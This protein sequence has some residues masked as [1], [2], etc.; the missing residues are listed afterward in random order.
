[1]MCTEQEQAIQKNI[2]LGSEELKKVDAFQYLGSV[3][4]AD[5]SEDREITG[6]I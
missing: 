3:I 4:P 1:M 2:K 6:R 5:G